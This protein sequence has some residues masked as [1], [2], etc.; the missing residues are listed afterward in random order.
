MF[1]VRNAAQASPLQEAHMPR[2]LIFGGSVAACF[3]LA[4]SAPVFA[5]TTG[6]GNG[7]YAVESME[8]TEL[9]DGSIAVKVHQK[10]F[11]TGNTASNPFGTSIQDCTGSGTVGTDGSQGMTYGYCAGIDRF[12]DVF[13]I[14]WNTDGQAGNWGLMGGTGK[15]DGMTATGTTRQLTEWSDGRNIISWEGTWE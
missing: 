14:W 4:F 6:G 11:V 2:K 5:Q 13:F 1:P 12:G 9:P 8:Q 10:G 7:F 15:F 3:L